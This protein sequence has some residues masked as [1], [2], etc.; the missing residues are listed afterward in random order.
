[1]RHQR[2]TDCTCSFFFFF[3]TL[4]FGVQGLSSQRQGGIAAGQF[5]VAVRHGPQA[6]GRGILGLTGASQDPLLAAGTSEPKM[7][8]VHLLS[9]CSRRMS[10]SVLQVRATPSG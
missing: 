8:Q 6:D 2:S 10:L 5:P 3:R 9:A 7:G 1:M 4:S